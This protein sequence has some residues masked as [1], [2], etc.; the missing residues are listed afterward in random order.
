MESTC[1]SNHCERN[2]RRTRR[3]RGTAA[4]KHVDVGE[5]TCPAVRPG[6]PILFKALTGP[7]G[8]IGI[9]GPRE[10]RGMGSGNLALCGAIFSTTYT[11]AGMSVERAQGWSSQLRLT[12]L[13]PAAYIGMRVATALVL[14]L[15]PITVVNVVG[16]ILTHKTSMPVYP[17]DRQ[18]PV[19]LDRL[20]A[21]HGDLL[22]AQLS[23]AGCRAP[24]DGCS[25]RCGVV[26]V[27]APARGGRASWRRWSAASRRIH[28]VQPF[29]P[30]S[31]ADRARCRW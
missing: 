27:P 13:S 23:V 16:G 24:R 22:P 18:R 29:H 9:R 28:R 5:V 12:P 30:K 1:G 4:G 25:D 14:G 17:V 21:A 26:W 20:A 8:T 11:G 7:E 31:G 19:R 15:V 10:L 6:V 2:C 3:P